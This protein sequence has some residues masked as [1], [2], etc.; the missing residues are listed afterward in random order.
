MKLKEAKKIL[1]SETK[2]KRCSNSANQYVM[3]ESHASLQQT[4]LS[5]LHPIPNAGISEI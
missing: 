1:R 3:E 5:F 4:Y 2:E